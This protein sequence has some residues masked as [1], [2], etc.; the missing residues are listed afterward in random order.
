M[1]T[2]LVAC[3][4]WRVIVVVVVCGLVC[5]LA[6]VFA[7]MATRLERMAV[8][9][10]VIGGA[11]AGLVVAT[12]AVDPGV[13][14]IGHSLPIAVTLLVGAVAMALTVLG[15]MTVLEVD[16]RPRRQLR[17][18]KLLLLVPLVLLAVQLPTST[19]LTA[20]AVDDPADGA[21]VALTLLTIAAAALA[22]PLLVRRREAT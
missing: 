11:A 20:P 8:A 17:P 15:A 12:H 6:G 1:T 22:V 19:V 4:Q 7:L 13:D 5:T 21:A 16:A 14:G 3:Y 2:A 9:V 18:W 10:V